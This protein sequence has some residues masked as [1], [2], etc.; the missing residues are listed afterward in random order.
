MGVAKA[1]GGSFKLVTV[2]PK[3]KEISTAQ[4]NIKHGVDGGKDLLMVR[5]YNRNDALS[6]KFDFLKLLPSS[7]FGCMFTSTKEVMY[8]LAFVCLLVNRIMKNY[9]TDFHKIRWKG[10][11]KKPL[12]VGGNPDQVTSGLRLG[13]DKPCLMS[14]LR[15]T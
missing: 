3:T 1:L 11:C 4:G 9:Q 5:D 14:L 13:G 10:P 6:S 7:V 2:A 8:S 12:N 15:L